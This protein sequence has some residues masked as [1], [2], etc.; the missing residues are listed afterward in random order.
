MHAVAAARSK[1][2]AESPVLQNVLAWPGDDAQPDDQQLVNLP[3]L[4]LMIC[5]NP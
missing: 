2:A 3:V 1:T 5:A 4:S